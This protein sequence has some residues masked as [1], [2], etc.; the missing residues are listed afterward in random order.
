MAGIEIDGVSNKIELNTGAA[1]ADQ[2]IL[3]NGNAQDFYIALDDSAD[4]L[5]IGLGSTVGTTPIISVDEN[6]DVAIPDG[7]L[8]ITT[9]DNT[10]QLSLVSTDADANS[11]PELD[12]YRNSGSP[13][14]SDYIGTTRYIG[15]NDNS[16][17]VNFVAI[18]VQANDVSDG[19][20]DGTYIINTMRNGASDQTFN[21]TPTEVIINEDSK[22]VDFRVES[23]GNANMIFVDGGKDIVNIGTATDHSGLLNL[24]SDNDGYGIFLRTANT[25]NTTAAIYIDKHSETDASDIRMIGFEIADQGRGFIKAGADDSTAPS[26]AAGSDRRLKKNITAYTGGY[27]KI[28]S[29]PVQEWDEKYTSSTGRTG[30]IADELET[31]FPKAVSGTADG[32]RTAIKAIIDANG[33]CLRENTTEE[34]LEQ[35][36]EAG[37]YANCTFEESVTVPDFQF[38]SP[39]DFYADVVQALQKSIEKIETLETKVAALE[40]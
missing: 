20:E 30:W 39:L 16:Q 32:T 23:N 34:I 38:S 37:H 4:D 10:T 14:D 29:I 12:Y 2:H 21:I 8:T 19:T 17:D 1:A 26:F 18:N 11:G 3:F 6:K 15:R 24:D 22:D 40:G 25:T 35:E 33:R 36:Q 7:G 28:K 31:V 27:E 9:S 13:A 5:I